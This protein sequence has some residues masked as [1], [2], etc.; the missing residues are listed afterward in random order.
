MKIYDN[1]HGY[2]SIDPIAKS[3][4]DTPVFQRLRSIHQTGVLYL[5]YPTAVHS[6]FEHS[7]GTYYLAKQMITCL[8]NKQPEL[9]ITPDIIMMVSIAGLCHDLGHL[10]FS[11]LF[12]DYFLPQLPNYNELVKQTKNTIH[13]NRSI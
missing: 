2:I 5:V 1:I 4:I 12:D 3:I 6:R 9:N 8:A 11:H 13:E 10:M 7:I